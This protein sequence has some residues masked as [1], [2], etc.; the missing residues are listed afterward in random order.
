MKTVTVTLETLEVLVEL[1]HHGLEQHKKRL[2]GLAPAQDVN[3][4]NDRVALTACINRGLRAIDK[5]EK[6]VIFS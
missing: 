2:R 5:A 4:R 3:E 1:A 6:K